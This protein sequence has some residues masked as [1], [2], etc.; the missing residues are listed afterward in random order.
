MLAFLTA[1]GKQYHAIASAAGLQVIFLA[2]HAA[3][4]TTLPT[5]VIASIW[6]VAAMVSLGM[7]WAEEHRAR[8]R[9]EAELARFP[10]LSLHFDPADRYCLELPKPRQPGA[11]LWFTTTE[12]RV[13]I[14]NRGGTW[15][16]GARLVVLDSEPLIKG[17]P[18]HY[19]SITGQELDAGPFDVAPTSDGRPTK[20]V[21]LLSHSWFPPHPSNSYPGPH[22][23]L[24]LAGKYP[25][26]I[27][28]G[29]LHLKLQ[30][31]AEVT[32]DPLLLKINLPQDGP[33]SVE[34]VKS[35]PAADAQQG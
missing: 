2:A 35:W 22:V 26:D 20:Y 30:L 24:Y 12:I 18:P 5:A 10:K 23:R 16:R 21:R 34:T 29:V 1:V 15:A 9:A 3:Y 4:G 31:V 28:G 11:D 17:H 8:A 25:L 27:P 6:I 32:C 19:D 33:A 13:A 7:A 14:S